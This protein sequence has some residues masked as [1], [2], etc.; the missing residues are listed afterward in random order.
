MAR[1]VSI[2]RG[3]P[4]KAT[5]SFSCSSRESSPTNRTFSLC[6]S[7]N[8]DR[9]PNNIVKYTKIWDWSMYLALGH[10]QLSHKTGSFVPTHIWVLAMLVSGQ[11]SYPATLYMWFS[12]AIID[13]SCWLEWAHDLSWSNK[14]PMTQFAT[15]QLEVYL[16]GL[17][18]NSLT[19]NT[20][21]V[22]L[23]AFCNSSTIQYP[24]CSTCSFCSSWSRLVSSR[25]CIPVCNFCS[26]TS[27]SWVDS[28]Y[29]GNVT[30]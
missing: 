9:F 29:L 5:F 15:Q 14:C 8:D 22:T 24:W 21:Q 25:T 26:I 12:A 1:F 10:T 23:C 20:F 17:M 6:R 2:K 13:E 11:P 27:F 7:C 4:S 16:R 19:T 3:S 18:M 28:S 30:L